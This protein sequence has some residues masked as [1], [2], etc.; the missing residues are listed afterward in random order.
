MAGTPRFRSQLGLDNWVT[1]DG[2]FNILKPLLLY[3][4]NDLF[5]RGAARIVKIRK[6][7][8]KFRFFWSGQGRNFLG[9]FLSFSPVL[10]IP[11]AETE[12]VSNSA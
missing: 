1:L 2:L 7:F 3:N 10:D 11:S 4:N 12:A 6:V 8:R 9:V 5:H